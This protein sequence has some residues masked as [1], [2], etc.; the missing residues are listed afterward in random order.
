M[1]KLR[2]LHIVETLCPSGTIRSLSSVIDR[3]SGGVWEH[4]VIA[5][6]GGCFA[7]RLTEA[8][9]S[10]RVLANSATNS[11]TTKIEAIRQANL[12]DWDLVHLWDSSTRRIIGPLS[13]ALKRSPYILSIRDPI[14]PKTWIGQRIE[15]FVLN[16]AAAVVFNSPSLSAAVSNRLAGEAAARERFT[17]IDDVAAESPHEGR[18]P[19]GQHLRRELGIGDDVL[20]IGTA[21]RITRH[22]D[23]R[24]LIFAGALM[25]LAS[26]RVRIVILGDGP[27][28]EALRRFCTL[29]RMDDL[30][31]FMGSRLD[32][33]SLIADFDVFVDCAVADGPSLGIAE[34]QAAGVPVVCADSPVRRAQVEFDAGRLL[35]RAG[36][37]GELTRRLYQLHNDA[38]LRRRLGQLGACK[39]RCRRPLAAVA[40]DFTVLYESIAKR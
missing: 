7:D 18:N 15:N 10:V 14:A 3:T 26:E 8:G 17:V 31:V 5:L 1:K 4:R 24:C 35:F 6:Q 37:P 27:E 12:S 28:C 11:A 2:L 36:D 22:K 23:V 38:E 39:S 40:R 9:A 19:R 30:T 29:M 13:A 34:A 20:V 21:A 25:R 16:R 33:P 32:A